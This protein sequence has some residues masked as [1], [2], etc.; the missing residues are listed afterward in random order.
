MTSKKKQELD[1]VVNHLLHTFGQ[2]LLDGWSALHYGD[3]KRACAEDLVYV[4][5]KLREWG[6]I[7]HLGAA[8]QTH[9]NLKKATADKSA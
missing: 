5:K 8:I 7:K 6:H 3:N 4:H 1:Q 2:D 9:D